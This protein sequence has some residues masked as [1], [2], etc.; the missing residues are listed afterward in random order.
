MLALAGL[1]IAGGV[2]LRLWAVLTLG[3][4][5][6]LDVRADPDQP[7][8]SSGPFAVIRHPSY[9]AMLVILIGYGLAW[10]TALTVAATISVF[11][12][13]LLRRIR[14]EETALVDIL[15]DRYRVYA[16]RTWRLVPGIW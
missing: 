12:P 16:A 6:R 10:G 1:L 3:R 8:V 15:G 14:L 5:F 11:L 9:A 13:A 7:V 4:Y 2:A